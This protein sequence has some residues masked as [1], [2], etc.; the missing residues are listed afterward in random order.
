MVK[1]VRGQCCEWGTEAWGD[2][3]DRSFSDLVSYVVLEFSPKEA[4]SIA[5]FQ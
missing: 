3:C 5:N 2:Q 4:E 1:R